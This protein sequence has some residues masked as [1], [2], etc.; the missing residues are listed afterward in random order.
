MAEQK[1]QVNP[2]LAPTTHAA[3]LAYC[4]EHNATQSEVVEAALG[5]WLTPSAEGETSQVILEKLLRVEAAQGEMQAAFE[6]VVG[7]LGAMLKKMEP[8]APVETASYLDMYTE[9]QQHRTAAGEEPTEEPRDA[10]T[11]EMLSAL[12]LQTS[13]TWWKWGRR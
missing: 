13:S 11:H 9:L 1:M 3:M 8:P 5:A 10:T 2:K 6:K 4:K 7:V 12:P